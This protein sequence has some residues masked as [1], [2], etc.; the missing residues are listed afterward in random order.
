MVPL[1]WAC[2][3]AGHEVRIAGTPGIC[4]TIVHTGLAAVIVGHDVP[5]ISP[6]TTGIIARIYGHRRFPTDWPLHS[7]RLDE[8][9]RELLA[10]LGK[11]SAR[12]AEGMVDDLIRFGRGWRPDLVVHDTASFAGP[13]AAAVLGLPNLRHL[14]GVGLRPMEKPVP[15]G[16]VLPEFA[17]LFDRFDVPPRGVPTTT[18]DPSPPSLRLPVEGPCV[19]Q[20]FV[21]YN[22]HGSQPRWL[23]APRVRPRVCVTWGFSVLR[24]AAAIGPVAL[25]PY[26]DAI[27]G[28][29]AAGVEVVLVT[30]ARHLEYLGRLPE[31]VLIAESAPLHLVLPYCDLIVHQA[32]DGTALTA[33]A[34]GV[35]QVAVTSKPDPALTA[36]RLADFGAATHLR[37]QEMTSGPERR[38]R[39][40]GAVEKMLADSAY[41]AA[42]DRLRQEIRQQPAPAETVR[43]LVDLVAQW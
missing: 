21:P 23:L 20:R 35:P 12:A 5:P 32:G 27:E 11:N 25:S 18:V 36:E 6:D 14:T 13:V 31:T 15:G 26:R 28:A 2:R 43:A 1:A 37:S 42:A 3:A 8:E 39:V 10:V 40:R 29:A 38:E 17:A 16:E 19:P 9:Q 41:Q 33:A 22:G 4:E 7:D 34:L 30:T 24:A